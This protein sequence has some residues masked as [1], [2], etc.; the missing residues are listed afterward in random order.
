MSSANASLPTASQPTASQCCKASQCLLP[1]NAALPP[2]LSPALLWRGLLQFWGPASEMRNARSTRADQQWVK[3]DGSMGNRLGARLW[4]SVGT[5]FMACRSE[6]GE[7]AGLQT[8]GPQTALIWHSK[9]VELW[10]E[11]S[12]LARALPFDVC[13]S[14]S[15]FFVEGGVARAVYTALQRCNC[16][17]IASRTSITQW[18]PAASRTSVTHWASAAACWHDISDSHGKGSMIRSR[19]QGKDG[20]S[21]GIRNLLAPSAP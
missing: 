21:G 7:E 10:M 5:A 1:P 12:T 13:R 16:T 17:K 19:C 11:P 3:R 20:P 2:T 14:I 8:W 4:R 18:A 6:L 9:C 15:H